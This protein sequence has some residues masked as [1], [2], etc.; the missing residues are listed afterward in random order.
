MRWPFARWAGK[1]LPTEAE[2]EFAAR[3]GLEGKPFVW[4]DE[5]PTGLPGPA[6]IWQGEFPHQNTAIDGFARTAP[7]RSFPP[8]GYWTVRHGWKRLGMVRRLV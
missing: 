5:P 6:N 4:G 8:N 7:V 2:W 1:R 3:G